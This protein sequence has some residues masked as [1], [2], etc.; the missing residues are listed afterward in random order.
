MTLSPATESALK[1]W[2]FA[3]MS[4]FMAYLSMPGFISPRDIP[5]AIPYGYLFFCTGIALG[6]VG[7]VKLS[8]S[9]YG[10]NRS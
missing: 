7:F 6:L 5:P 2:V 3:G 4:F 9:L 1:M 8:W 10:G